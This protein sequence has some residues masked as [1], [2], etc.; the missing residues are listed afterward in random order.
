MLN[1][2]ITFNIMKYGLC[3]FFFLL[4]TISLSAQQKNNLED[5]ANDTLI[6]D[7]GCGQCQFGI[8]N[9]KGC[10]LAVRMNDKVYFVVGS[11]IDDHGDAHAEDGFCNAIRKAKVTGKIKGRK[12]VASS[13]VLLPE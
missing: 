3:L 1:K 4:M 5:T 8:K 2:K 11:K 10:D 12:F 6:V 13:F 7:A 9:V